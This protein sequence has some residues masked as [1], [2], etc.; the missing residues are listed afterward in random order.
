MKIEKSKIVEVWDSNHNK[1]LEYTQVIK[2]KELNDSKNIIA[3][4]LNDLMYKVRAQV[5]EWKEPED[6]R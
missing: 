6:L 2:N 5:N 3:S 1:I 4:N